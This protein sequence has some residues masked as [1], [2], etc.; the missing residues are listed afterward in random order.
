VITDIREDRLTL[1]KE[2]G[3][4]AA[5]NSLKDSLEQYNCYFDIAFECSGATACLIDASK[6]LNGRKNRCSWF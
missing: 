4:S 2:I 1:A 5:I 3:A 6:R